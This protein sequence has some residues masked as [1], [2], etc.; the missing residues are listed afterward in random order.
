MRVLLRVL[1]AAALGASAASQAPARDIQR[2]A[3]GTGAGHEL[4]YQYCEFNGSTAAA[5][6]ALGAKQGD[7]KAPAELGRC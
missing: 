6:P 2:G 1:F 3:L 5:A 7:R 4:E